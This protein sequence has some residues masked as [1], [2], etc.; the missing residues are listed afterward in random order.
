MFSLYKLMFKITKRNKPEDILINR[1]IENYW[2]RSY[3]DGSCMYLGSCNYNFNNYKIGN[4]IDISIL[5][6]EKLLS[7]KTTQDELK[8]MTEHIADYNQ[9][10]PHNLTNWIIDRKGL[11]KKIHYFLYL[12][13]L[14]QKKEDISSITEGVRYRLI[15]MY[16]KYYMNFLNDI[17]V[18]INFL[19]IG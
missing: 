1:I 13:F 19:T 2:F 14:L 17:I 15:Q 12:I 9:Q 8:S 3:L 11:Y 5:L 4:S 16:K 18:R 10:Y 6:L 7:N